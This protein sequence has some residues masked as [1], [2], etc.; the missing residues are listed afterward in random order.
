MWYINKNNIFPL[1]LRLA[2]I[3]LLKATLN[4][5][6]CHFGIKCSSFC[7]VNIGTSMRSACTS[8]GFTV[9]NSVRS[10]NKLLERM[11]LPKPLVV[12]SRN[13]C[14]VFCSICISFWYFSTQGIYLIDIKSKNHTNIEGDLLGKMRFCLDIPSNWI[15]K[16]NTIPARTCTLIL[17]STALGGAWTLEQPSGSLLEFYPTWRFV[18]AAICKS[19]G[20]F[21]A[22]DLN[23]LFD[24]MDICT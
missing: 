2:I 8:L 6:A 1:D 7:K 15:I 21:A 18:L 4:N 19:G 5:F 13:Q 20:P 11:G 10:S 17:L 12:C 16:S 9:Y 3:S 23:T 14:L 22:M 24:R